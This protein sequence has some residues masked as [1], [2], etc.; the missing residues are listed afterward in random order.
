[1]N[2]YLKKKFLGVL[3]NMKNNRIPRSENKVKKKIEEER[4]LQI[5]VFNIFKIKEFQQFNKLNLTE[6]EISSLGLT[7]NY[8]KMS[9]LFSWYL[10]P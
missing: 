7:P 5:P 2:I 9:K 10:C 6:I 3:Q 8:D 4:L 1:M